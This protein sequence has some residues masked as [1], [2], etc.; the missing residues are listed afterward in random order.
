MLL[1]AAYLGIIYLQE[2][3]YNS[4]LHFLLLSQVTVLNEHIQSTQTALVMDVL[5]SWPHP[6]RGLGEGSE[7]ICLEV[8]FGCE[9]GKLFC[10]TSNDNFLYLTGLLQSSLPQTLPT[11]LNTILKD[12]PD[13]K[14]PFWTLR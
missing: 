12:T 13:D 5:C 1:Q 3:S 8:G 6:L 7:Q 9:E 2:T 4:T 11:S 10:F 14:G